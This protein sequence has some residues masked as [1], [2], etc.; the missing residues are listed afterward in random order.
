MGIAMESE[1]DTG[2]V[3]FPAIF[4]TRLEYCRALQSLSIRQ[5]ELIQANDYSAMLQVLSQKQQ[6]LERFDSLNQRHPEL[7]QLWQNTREE[8]EPEWRSDCEQMLAES[9]SILDDVLQRDNDGTELLSERRD[10]TQRQ[11]QSIASGSQVH[12]AY[13]D[14]LAPVTH[15]HLDVD[16]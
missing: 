5:M 6:L 2:V 16:Q 4:K 7:W 8:L 12:T 9:E 11:L 13:R 15:R 3:D 14:S 1:T 10:Q